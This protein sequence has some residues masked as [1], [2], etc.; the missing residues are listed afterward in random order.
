M[1]IRNE[2]RP[3][4]LR[5]KLLIWRQAGPDAPGRMVPYDV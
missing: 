5:L 2:A 3:A 4:K 1:K